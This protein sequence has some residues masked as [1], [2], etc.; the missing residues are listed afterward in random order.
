MKVTH[1]YCSIAAALAVGAFAV[2]ANAAVVSQQTTPLNLHSGTNDVNV[3]FETLSYIVNGSSAVLSATITGG[4]GQIT[5]TTLSGTD[6][7]GSVSATAL[8][9]TVDFTKNGSNNFVATDGT[10]DVT[11]TIA[12]ISHN[13]F[14][15]T[16]LTNFAFT[17]GT[18][19]QSMEFEFAQGTGDF[20]SLKTIGV[21]L[22]G[23][24]SPAPDAALDTSFSSSFLSNNVDVF[25]VPEPASLAILGLAAPLFLRRKA[26]A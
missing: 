13:L 19:T 1:R 12:S 22:H 24:Y 26:R 23:V 9:L 14:H 18:S 20:G 8:T 17:P 2:S 3:A 25:S 11:G 16:A 5:G 7:N 10:L 4:T 21:E 6:P 15:S